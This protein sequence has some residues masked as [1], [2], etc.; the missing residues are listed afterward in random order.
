MKEL[1]KSTPIINMIKTYV[2]SMMLESPEPHRYFRQKNLKMRIDMNINTR[3]NYI[4]DDEFEYSVAVHI[5]SECESSTVYI[6][7]MNQMGLFSIKKNQ[8]DDNK[9]NGLIQT[10][11]PTIL[12]PYLR[13]SISNITQRAG[14]EPL[15]INPVNLQAIPKT[16][17]QKEGNAIDDV[18]ETSSSIH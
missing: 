2:K 4:N 18:E 11:C 3:M 1:D 8:F 5:R 13:E 14:F 16:S 15:L 7:D 9:I 10:T 17:K 12:L 6:I